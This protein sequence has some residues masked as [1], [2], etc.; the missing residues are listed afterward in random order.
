MSKQSEH[1]LVSVCI[2]RHRC[3]HGI[4]LRPEVPGG[5]TRRLFGARPFAASMRRQEV[6]S[7]AIAE[8]PSQSGQSPCTCGDGLSRRPGQILAHHVTIDPASVLG[9]NSDQDP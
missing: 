8:K 1:Q 6:R 7:P 9:G 4:D 5:A 2:V 3:E